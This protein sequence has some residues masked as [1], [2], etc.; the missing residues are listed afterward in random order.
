MSNLRLDR[1]F[2]AVVVASN[3]VNHFD[4]VFRQRLLEVAAA[5]LRVHARLG[6]LLADAGLVLQDLFGPAGTWVSAVPAG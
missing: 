6:D 5:H 2:D 4:P 3:L 1:C